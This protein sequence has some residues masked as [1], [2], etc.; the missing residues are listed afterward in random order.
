MS[1]R[2]IPTA[3]VWGA[4]FAVLAA[5]AASYALAKP[6]DRQILVSELTGRSAAEVVTI[7]RET[8]LTIEPLYD[9]SEVISDDELALVLAQVVPRFPQK[10]LKPNYV[11]HALR[12]WWMKARFSDPTVMSGE[13][14]KDYL[15]DHGRYLASWGDDI[16][17]L[18]QERS[19]G[20]AVRWGKD[21]CASVHHDHWLACL[22]EAGMSLNEPVFTPNRRHHTANDVL[23]EAIRDFRLDEVETEWSSLAFALWMAPQKTWRNRSG[24][25]LSFDLMVDRLVRGDKKLGVCA[26]THRVYSLM[27]LIRLDDE[28]H[29]LTDEGRKTAWSYL[30]TVRDAITVSQFPD[31][32]W[33]SNWPDGADAVKKPVEEELFKKVIAT[34]HHLEWLAIAPRELHPPREHILKAARWVIRTTIQQTPSDIGQ[35]YTFFSH[36]GNAMA[37]WRK[38]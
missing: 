37:L 12:T 33:P 19:N 27:A 29:I 22:T 13:Q 21:L 9:D 15:V 1:H 10:Q 16:D 31:G 36:V 2:T 26:G 23:Q 14:M 18:L 11:E 5:F 20:V 32:H 38:T 4:Q 17:P 34:G 35:R 6:V 25:E 28:Y 24:R 30:E 7:P 8:A 3:A